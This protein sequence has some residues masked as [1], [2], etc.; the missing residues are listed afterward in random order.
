[1]LVLAELAGDVGRLFDG[2]GDDGADA[3]F[4]HG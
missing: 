3:A 2:A 1:V 4:F